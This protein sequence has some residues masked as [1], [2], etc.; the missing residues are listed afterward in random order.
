MDNLEQGQA[1]FER[2]MQTI[3]NDVGLIK[4]DVVVWATRDLC[5][6]IT[7]DTL[8]L[9]TVHILNRTDLRDILNPLAPTLEQA[10][11]LSF[12]Q[13]DL[14]LECENRDGGAREYVAVEASYTADLRDS[15]RA[16]RNAN[17]L[18][19]CIEA[20]AHAVVA[21][22]RNVH[23]VQALVDRGELH[24]YRLMQKDLQPD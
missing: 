15:D 1:R 6:F 21:S 3:Q 9:D 16:L 13:E 7:E 8:A 23:E 20:P 11:R 12:Y 4:V 5:F 2:Q 24:W 18:T 22:V 19:Q 17:L 14:V 10:D